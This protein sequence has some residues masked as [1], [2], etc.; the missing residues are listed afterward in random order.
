[1]QLSKGAVEHIIY[2]LFWGTLILSPFWGYFLG[3]FHSQLDWELI[4]KFWLYLLPALVLFL[5]NNYFLMPFLLYRKR[6]RRYLFFLICSI[7]L[8]YMAFVLM[9]P[10]VEPAE[11]LAQVPR[12][13]SMGLFKGKLLERSVP[14]KTVSVKYRGAQESVHDFFVDNTTCRVILPPMSRGA[15]K[16]MSYVFFHPDSVQILLIVFVLAFN[17]CV[18]LFFL[19]MR[20]DEYLREVEEQ[21]L[22]SELGYL[23]YQINPHF[24]MNTLN[25]I[26]ALIDIDPDLARRAVIELSKIMRHVLYESSSLLVSLHS[27]IKF[28]KSYVGLMRLRYTDVLKLEFSLPENADNCVVPSL[29]FA[30]FIENAFKH[31]VSYNRESVIKVNLKVEDGFVYFNC[32]NSCNAIKEESSKTGIGLEN[33]RSRLALI[34]GDNYSLEIKKDNTIFSIGLKIPARNDEMYIG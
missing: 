18:R 24:F 28:M 9:V 31:G 22:R 13:P 33:V 6:R 21:K 4:C 17:V 11:K 5:I 19:T 15:E 20:N 16:D 8:V 1:M 30:S 25:N 26:H 34:Y 7:S 23:K 27:E 29:I 3:G 32:V 14:Y 12:R 10:P 2:T